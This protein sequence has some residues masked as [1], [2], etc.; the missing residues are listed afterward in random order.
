MTDKGSGMG[1]WVHQCPW[2][3]WSRDASSPTILAPRC[4]TCGGMLE[5]VPA[6]AAVSAV[7]PLRVGPHLSPAYGRVAR[8]VL[9]GLLLFAAGRFGWHAGGFGLALTGIGVVGL[10]TV[11]LI[12]GD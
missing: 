12:V 2:C 10:F 3:G 4:T 5:A 1:S 11:P 8:F 9:V 6:T 7:S